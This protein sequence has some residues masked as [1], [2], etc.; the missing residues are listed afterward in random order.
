MEI[1]ET[2]YTLFIC[3]IPKHLEHFLQINVFENFIS[4]LRIGFSMVDGW[5]AGWLTLFYFYLFFNFRRAFKIAIERS[6]E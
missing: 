6:F 4:F 3:I 1:V 5:L 2:F